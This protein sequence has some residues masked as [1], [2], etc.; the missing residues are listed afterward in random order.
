MTRK[1]VW[2]LQDVRDMYLQDKWDADSNTLWVWGSNNY[3]EGG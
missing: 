3:G 1:G 2:G